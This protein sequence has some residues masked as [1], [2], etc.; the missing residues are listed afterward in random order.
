MKNKYIIFNSV[1]FLLIVTSIYHLHLY[2][3]YCIRNN[4]LQTLLLENN[5]SN[6][7]L[8]NQINDLSTKIKTLRNVS[9]NK[10]IDNRES[11]NQSN[12][13]GKSASNLV[14]ALQNKI[15]EHTNINDNNNDNDNKIFSEQSYLLIEP[16]QI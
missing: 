1:G 10:L 5:Y 11:S 8:L 6:K 4:N 13:L 7:V 9:A 12:K 16:Q 3:K 2:R 14:T 15:V